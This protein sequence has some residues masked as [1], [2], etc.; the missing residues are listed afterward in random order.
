MTWYK[1]DDD[2]K[3]V[4]ISILIVL[5]L[6]DAVVQFFLANPFWIL[7]FDIGQLIVTLYLMYLWFI[8][9]IA[10]VREEI[11]RKFQEEYEKLD[12]E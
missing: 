1:L 3:F 2:H 5:I 11:W 8:Y 9:A 6:I 4:I 7:F 10:K 12:N